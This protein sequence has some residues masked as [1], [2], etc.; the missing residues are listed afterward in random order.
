MKIF[1]KIVIG[2]TV[3]LCVVIVYLLVN[4]KF[5]VIEDQ[6]FENIENFSRL[7]TDQQVKILSLI[8][9]WELVE[10]SVQW[11]GYGYNQDWCEKD[12]IYIGRKITIQTDGTAI[13]MNEKYQVEMSEVS[14]YG[15][16]I[17]MGS[18]Y[19]V[20][21][22]ERLGEQM[23]LTFFTSGTHEYRF[24]IHIGEDGQVYYHDLVTGGLYSME[25]MNDK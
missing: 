20:G 22:A 2:S 23:I 1:Q 11:R 12:D 14:V 17:A 25:K 10:W 18:G 3:V 16:D 6:G 7:T 13:Y 8:G 21:D 19:T 15:V 9:E 4:Q 5:K 24:W